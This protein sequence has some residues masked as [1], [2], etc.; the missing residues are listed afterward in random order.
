MF[1]GK[2][3]G[4]SLKTVKMIFFGR[5]LILLAGYPNIWSITMM[6]SEWNAYHCYYYFQ[7]VT[8]ALN[9]AF[10]QYVGIFA[11]IPARKPQILRTLQSRKRLCRYILSKPCPPRLRRLSHVCYRR[12]WAAFLWT[13]RFG[14]ARVA[15][16]GPVVWS[17]SINRPKPR[18]SKHRDQ[19]SLHAKVY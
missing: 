17:S 5:K 18:D 12:T 1:F 15:C 9:Y 2:F 6:Y 19:V 11:G 13:T 10:H 14:A 3:P 16:V 4:L 8:R 7:I